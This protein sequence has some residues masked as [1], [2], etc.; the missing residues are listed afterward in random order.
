MHDY[1]ETMETATGRHAT[2]SAWV[3][4]RNSSHVTLPRREPEKAKWKRSTPPEYA[5]LEACTPCT[6]AYLI[7]RH[8]R[9]YLL[10]AS[11]LSLGYFDFA[12]GNSMVLRN[13]ISL[14]Q[15]YTALHLQ[16]ISCFYRELNYFW[17]T[18]RS[19]PLHRLSYQGSHDWTIINELTL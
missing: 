3:G 11:C 13:V 2:R 9:G 18:S 12:D 7:G 17:S 6:S 1:H 4:L 15:D 19:Q 8:V 5:Y 14:L 16:K 10:P